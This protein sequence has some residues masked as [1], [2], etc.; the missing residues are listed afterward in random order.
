MK[1]I[2][3]CLLALIV[4]VSMLCVPAAAAREEQDVVVIHNGDKALGGLS[5]QKE[6][7]NEGNGALAVAG[8]VC[9]VKPVCLM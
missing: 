6:V 8:G 3:P 5:S 4:L 2:I 1:R 7:V 9:H